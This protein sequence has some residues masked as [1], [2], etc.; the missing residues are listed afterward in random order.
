MSGELGAMMGGLR[1]RTQAQAPRARK[2]GLNVRKEMEQEGG[3]V[4]H[5]SLF[6]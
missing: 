5:G 4:G 2:K 1:M 3:K 6:M